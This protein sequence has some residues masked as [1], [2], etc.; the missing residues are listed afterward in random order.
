M[1]LI[2]CSSEQFITGKIVSISPYVVGNDSLIRYIVKSKDTMS[3]VISR[4][5]G[6]QKDS[7]YT[8]RVKNF[9]TE[10]PTNNQQQQ[11]QRNTQNFQRGFGQSF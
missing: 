8:F 2:G 9:P 5:K 10:T 1:T 11:Q 6:Y 7:T 4:Y 3:E